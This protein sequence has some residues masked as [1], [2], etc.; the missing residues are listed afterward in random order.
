MID[1][2]AR[3]GLSQAAIL[4]LIA[5]YVDAVGYFDLGHVF[6]ANM[7]GNTVLLGVSVVKGDPIALNYVATIGAFALGVVASTLLKLAKMP[8][9]GSFLIAAAVLVGMAIAQ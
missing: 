8:L 9:P 4:C 7:T 6:T 5:G 3:A 1:Y 2:E